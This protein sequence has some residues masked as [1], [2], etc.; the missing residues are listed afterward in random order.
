M[1]PCRAFTLV[2]MMVVLTVSLLLMTMIAPIF[3]VST[4]TVQVI[5]RKL[6]VYEAAR[7]ILELIEADVQLAVT[8]ERGGHWSLKHV[9]WMDNDPFTATSPTPPLN[10]G[11]TDPQ[12]SAYK[13]SRRFSDSLGYIRLDGNGM[14]DNPSRIVG[15]KIFPLTYPG[16]DV[17]Y[18]EC[19]KAS[20]RT[21]LLY[22][23]PTEGYSSDYEKDNSDERW[24][25][26]EQLNDIGVIELAFI[27]YSAADQWRMTSPGNLLAHFDPVPDRFGPGKEIKVP[28]HFQTSVGATAQRRLAGMKIMD[29]SVS[30]WDDSP[31][32]GGGKQFKDMPDNTVVYFWPP[33]KAIRVTITVCDREKRDLLTLCRVIQIPLGAGNGVVD[34]AA[35]D[36]DYYA[37]AIFNRTKHLPKLPVYFNGDPSWRYENDEGTS[38]SETKELTS[39]GVKPLN[40]P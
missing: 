1:R 34:T 36:S 40:F 20:M 26:A 17:S 8:N 29:L 24:N 39:D 31:A 7:N 3:K 19:W 32:A 27:F 9:S 6:A 15:G 21:T 35:M 10:P 5:E 2:E 13:Q 37:P 22:Q 4:K 38:T 30:V 16:F 33:P 12:N 14:P 18:P 25:H 11:N 28:R 23:H